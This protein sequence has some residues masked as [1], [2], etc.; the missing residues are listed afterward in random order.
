LTKIIHKINEKKRDTIHM[1]ISESGTALT[2]LKLKEKMIDTEGK[3]GLFNKRCG[4]LS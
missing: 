2:L 1:T 3:T 4:K